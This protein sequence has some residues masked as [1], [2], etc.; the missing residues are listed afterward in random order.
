MDSKLQRG[1]VF[2]GTSLLVVYGVCCGC[3]MRFNTRSSLIAIT[4]HH[5]SLI[6]LLV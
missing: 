5:T 6:F 3:L 4:F 1:D 2:S